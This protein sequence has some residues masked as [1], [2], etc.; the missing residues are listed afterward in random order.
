MA[1]I[2]SI[3]EQKNLTLSSGLQNVFKIV[4][5]DLD[6]AIIDCTGFTTVTAYVAP[7]AADKGVFNLTNANMADFAGV[8]DVT[9]DATGAV[10]DVSGASVQT[11]A[12]LCFGLPMSYIIVLGDGTDTIRAAFGNINVQKTGF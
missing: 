10:L 5:R 4:P 12:D 9:L 8:D 1:L 2:D 3:A 7:Q 6:G 11:A